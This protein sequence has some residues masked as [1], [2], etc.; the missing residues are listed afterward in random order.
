MKILKAK[1]AEQNLE[2]QYKGWYSKTHVTSATH[3]GF[4]SVKIPD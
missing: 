4:F 3:S 2:F 1:I